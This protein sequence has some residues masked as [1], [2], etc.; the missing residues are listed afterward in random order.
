M[1]KKFINV[2]LIII[3]TLIVLYFSLKDNYD[4]IIELLLSSDIRWLFI[5]Y[6]FVL[7]YTFLK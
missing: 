2:I 7:S 5:G 1:K 4:E 3:F 6:L